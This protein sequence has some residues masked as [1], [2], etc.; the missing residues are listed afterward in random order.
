M[1]T[2]VSVESNAVSRRN[3]AEQVMKDLRMSLQQEDCLPTTLLEAPL[4]IRLLGEVKL[5]A[6]SDV[7]LRI[8]LDE[9][10]SG[11]KHLG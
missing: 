5:M 4:V 9:P 8:R 10:R 2:A 1:S 6:F 7:A 11:F 3:A